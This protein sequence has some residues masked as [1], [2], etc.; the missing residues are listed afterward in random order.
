MILVPNWVMVVA[1]SLSHTYIP[2]CVGL[3]AGLISSD[4]V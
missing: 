4:L 2:S 1:L 3:L